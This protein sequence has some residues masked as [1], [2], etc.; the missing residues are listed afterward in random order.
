VPGAEPTPTALAVRAREGDER[1]RS[2]LVERLA[3]MVGS[4]ARRFD[5]LVPRADLEQAGAVGV[6]AA[7]PSWDPTRGTAFE[8]YAARYAMGE[9]LACVREGTSYVRVPRSVRS[10]AR[11]VEAAIERHRRREGTS[12]TVAELCGETGLSEEQVVEALS[13]RRMMQPRLA[14]DDELSSVGDDDAAIARAEERLDLGAQMARLDARSRRILALRF[15]AGLSQSE[16]AARVGISQM[17][18]SRLLRQALAV[19]EQGLE[20]TPEGR[21]RT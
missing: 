2:E 3:P 11:D 4:L 1:A 16:I 19:L 21:G 7:L 20:A 8:T 6:L 14:D 10:A 9:M 15:G 5:R 13:A 18:V 17:H 12:P